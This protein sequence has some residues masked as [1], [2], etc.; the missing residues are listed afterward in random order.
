MGESY[1]NNYHSVST[2][3]TVDRY[4]LEFASTAQILLPRNRRAATPGRM[5]YAHTSELP[6]RCYF[7]FFAANFP[8][9]RNANGDP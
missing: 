8:I 3:R 7:A 5:P 2:L 1:E 4:P 6:R 9:P